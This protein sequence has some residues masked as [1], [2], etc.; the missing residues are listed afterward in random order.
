MNPSLKN[1]AN[2]K[3]FVENMSFNSMFFC[4][5]K[6]IMDCLKSVQFMD[7]F[8]SSVIRILFHIFNDKKANLGQLIKTQDK[9]WKNWL[10]YTWCIDMFYVKICKYSNCNTIN[11]HSDILLVI[12]SSFEIL[13]LLKAA[14]TNLFSSM[15]RLVAC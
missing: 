12:K 10:S 7:C 1:T 2:L 5:H 6:N 3:I 13:R 9:R 4:R 8:K 15:N 11:I 14:R